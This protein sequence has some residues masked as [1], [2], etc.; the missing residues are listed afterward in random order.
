MKCNI[1]HDQLAGKIMDSYIQSFV[2]DN[3]IDKTEDFFDSKCD[4]TYDPR[5]SVYDKFYFTFNGET[6]FTTFVP[7]PNSIKVCIFN[8][9]SK[10][11]FVYEIIYSPEKEIDDFF[12]WHDTDS[13]HNKYFNIEATKYYVTED[14]MSIFEE[15]ANVLDDIVEKKKEISALLA[16]RTNPGQPT[17]S[18]YMIDDVIHKF[19]MELSWMKSKKYVSE[20]ISFDEFLKL[21]IDDLNY[22]NTIYRLENRDVETIS[23][24]LKH[25]QDSLMLNRLYRIENVRL[26]GLFYVENCDLQDVSEFGYDTIDILCS[27]V[28]DTKPY[29]VIEIYLNAEE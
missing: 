9:I 17:A 8:K 2:I 26:N 11:V 7:H 20:R 29:K 4:N 25:F 23:K 10:L 1:I 21:D 3:L 24:L 22:N 14:N 5:N 15:Y 19:E 16:E 6:Y 13:D 27:P 18:T 12:K 28:N